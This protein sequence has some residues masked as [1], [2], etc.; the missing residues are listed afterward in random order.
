MALLWR[1]CAG[2]STRKRQG[3][4]ALLA[5]PPLC[6]YADM[7]VLKVRGSKLLASR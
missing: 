4:L 1:C 7:V 2:A 3:Y 5:G 6:V